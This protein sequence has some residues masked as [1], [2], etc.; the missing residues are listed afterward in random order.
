MHQ[1]YYLEKDLI[2]QAD[3][4]S[5]TFLSHESEEPSALQKEVEGHEVSFKKEK[6]LTEAILK[7]LREGV[8]DHVRHECQGCRTDHPSQKHHH[9]CLWTT[10]E[11]WINDYKYH[12]PA[13]ECLNIYDVIEDFDEII[14][15][16]MMGTRRKLTDAIHLLT[17][18]VTIE[19]YKNWQYFK[20]NQR[21]MTDQWKTFWAKKLLESYQETNQEPT[22]EENSSTQDWSESSPP[23]EN[24]YHTTE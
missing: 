10:S 14:W 13:L 4:Y 12:E 9:M 3:I 18:E 24:G 19:T 1:G 7:N 22:A 21:D 8:R 2:Y 16:Y 6:F 23:P 5:Q 15:E 11:E 20:K 17:P